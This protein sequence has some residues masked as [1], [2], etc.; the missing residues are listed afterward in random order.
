[1][2]IYIKNPYWNLL[3]TSISLTLPA[4]ANIC[5]EE[6]FLEGVQATAKATGVC[7]KGHLSEALAQLSKA[8][9]A[10]EEM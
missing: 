5:C 4:L 8:K 9:Q 7:D 1:M 6:C 2:Y 10:R 3:F